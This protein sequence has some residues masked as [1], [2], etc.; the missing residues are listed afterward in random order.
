MARVLVVGDLHLPVAHPGYLQ[1]C[2]DVYRRWRCNTVVFIGD[3]TDTH[4]ISFH[5]AHPEC[6]GPSDEYKLAKMH[7]ATW[8]RRFPKARICVGNHDERVIRLAESVNIPAKFLRNYQ[9]LWATPKW[10]WDYDFIIDNVY[11][12]HG[13]GNSGVH[14]AFNAM[15]KRLMSTVM[16]H[17]HSTAGI[18][19]LVN[20][21]KRIFAMDVG[22]GIDVRAFQFAYGKHCIQKPILSCG[23]VLDGTPYHEIMPCGDGEKYDRRRF[24]K[25]DLWR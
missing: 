11:Y 22:T 24:P 2:K 6:P 21:Q 4:A 14:P 25:R 7:I 12:F 10:T 3:V 19:W 1:F 5:A 15:K 8:Y 18:K 13:T 9:E 17:C 23:V 20:P 16:G